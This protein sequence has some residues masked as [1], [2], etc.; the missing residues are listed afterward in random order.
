MSKLFP[1]EV[2]AN[3]ASN[4]KFDDIP[5]DVINRITDLYVDWAGS[6]LSGKGHRAISI[7]ERFA[8]TMGP[9]SGPCQI[10]T[11]RKTSSPFFATLL[12]AAASHISEQ[13]DVHNGSVFHPA[14]IV[15][16]AALA[17]AQNQRCSGQDFLPLA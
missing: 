2:L 10:L 5:I 14:T 3:F 15:F 13:D 9:K 8:E 6:A 17:I 7:L 11:S 16:P 12:N 1:S 4:L